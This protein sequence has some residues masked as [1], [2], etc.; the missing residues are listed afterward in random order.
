[1][2]CFDHGIV[3]FK[4]MTS[5]YVNIWS[6]TM[7]KMYIFTRPGRNRNNMEWALSIRSILIRTNIRRR[8]NTY[9]VF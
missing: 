7:R 2:G 8:N 4:I 6:G 1:M 3:K 5:F 9:H